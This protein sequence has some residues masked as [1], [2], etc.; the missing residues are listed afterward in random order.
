MISA[1]LLSL[2]PRS[3]EYD[4]AGTPDPLPG[5]RGN[6]FQLE[7]NLVFV[8]LRGQEVLLFLPQNCCDSPNF[9]P[10]LFLATL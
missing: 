4:N 2:L 10:P 6:P 3:S 5:N 7:L 1:F 8:L 9:Y